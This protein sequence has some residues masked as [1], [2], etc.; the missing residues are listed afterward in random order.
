MLAL[1][2]VSSITANTNSTK[3][4]ET[5]NGNALKSFSCEWKDLEFPITYGPGIAASLCVLIGGFHL[6]FGEDKIDRCLHIF[7]IGFQ[8]RPI[9]SCTHAWITDKVFFGAS[10]KHSLNQIL[11]RIVER[12]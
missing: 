1:C 3:T 9:E 6:I 4:T 5:P 8:L 11:N 7:S 10:F 2:S 12:Q